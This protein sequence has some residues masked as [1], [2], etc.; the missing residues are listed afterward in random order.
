MNE[1]DKLPQII[2]L[3][4][5]KATIDAIERHMRRPTAEEIEAEIMVEI[6]SG[7]KTIADWFTE[8]GLEQ[9]K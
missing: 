2:V 7:K 4:I 9:P 8:K 3:G 1:T 5:I 6:K